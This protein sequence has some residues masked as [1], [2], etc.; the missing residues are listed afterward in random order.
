VLRTVVF[1]I[2]RVVK[3][4]LARKGRPVAGSPSVKKVRGLIA[5]LSLRIVE[6]GRAKLCPD[7]EMGEHNERWF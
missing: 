6:L 2:D 1:A 7:F 4:F 5:N 3:N